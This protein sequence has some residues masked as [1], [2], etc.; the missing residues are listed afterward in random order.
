MTDPRRVIH[1]EAEAFGEMVDLLVDQARAE[2]LTDE[3][4]AAVLIDRGES[5]E[6][7]SEGSA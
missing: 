6:R 2:G 1:A 4:I 5:A 7:R 3:A